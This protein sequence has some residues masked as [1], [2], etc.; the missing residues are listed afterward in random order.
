MNSL[1]AAKKLCFLFALISIPS[2]CMSQDFSKVEI[3]T[4]KVTN[5]VYMLQGAGGNIGVIIGENHLL[6]VDGQYA[7]LT[8]KI[9]SAV[10]TFS[11][12]EIKYLA[13]THWHGDHSGGNKNFHE[14][15]ATIIAH[16]NVR[17]RMSKPQ[18]MRAFGREVPASPD[19]A[20]P[21]I[22]FE[23]DLSVFMG[24]QK[25]VI[26]HVE[27]AHT[28]GDSFV[29]FPVENVL[30]LGDTYFNGNY[31]FIDVSS[32]GTIKGMIAAAN[33]ALFICNEETKIIPGHGPISNKTELSA[34]RDMLMKVF[35]RM[36]KA[37]DSN[38]TI[39][40]IK[41]SKPFQDLDGD[42]GNG[43]IKPD[44]MVDIIYSDLSR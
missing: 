2:L 18:L 21:T 8:E 34:Y 41:S 30:H 39:D 10:K 13:N 1:S 16:Q 7:P 28:D 37:I 29:Y 4:Q 27:N 3:K 38:L 12:K 17:E 19:E 35:D 14:K 36:K 44:V 5:N 42:W 15:G 11:D 26:M 9:I 40:E 32:G 20:L 24:E 25:I 43:F 6:L 23:D 22:V 33:N 31:P